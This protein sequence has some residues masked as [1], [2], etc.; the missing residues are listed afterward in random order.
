MPNPKTPKTPTPAAPA[1]DAN[2]P[3]E[4]PNPEFFI[5]CAPGLERE[6]E[7]ELRSW[8]PHGAGGA[9]LPD[10]SF[11]VQTDRGG[12]SVR[13]PLARGLELNRSMKTATRVLL[14]L[15]KFGC[16]DFPKLF[17]KVSSFPWAEVLPPTAAVDFQAST[18]G[19]RLRIKKRIEETAR[20]G[21]KS[22]LK[23]RGL[24]PK[25]ASAQGA[26]TFDVLL[27][28]DDDVCT[29]SLDTSGELLH[30][31]GYRPLSSDA[32]LRETLASALLLILEEVAGPSASGIELV[33]PMTGGGTF[34]IEAAG[35]S[36]EITTRTFAWEQSPELRTK[37]SALEP[38]ACSR[39]DPYASFLGF[40]SDEKALRSAQENWASA[41]DS[42]SAK[43]QHEDILKAA[44][45]AEGPRRW[46]VANPPYGERIRIEGSLK[47]Y[48]EKLFE[49]AERVVRPERACILL[50]EKA[51]PLTLML[52]RSWKLVR[53][54]PFSNGGLPV[55]ALVYAR[56]ETR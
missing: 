11:T 55:R 24:D 51:R 45:L 21:Y 36:R 53:D 37:A 50:P 34:L 38:M 40:D 44:P 54:V 12:I 48:Y 23:K 56:K 43:W 7:R 4:D 20:D 22:S 49:A 9:S 30:K 19:S 5:V 26:P 46:V 10:D 39:P 15:A 28:L 32:P 18:H 27:R 14:R 25:L 3:V 47:S 6:T 16:R 52:P 35:L 8:L 31:R 42:R 2:P 17:K 29:M 41:G 13:L 33:D 1:R